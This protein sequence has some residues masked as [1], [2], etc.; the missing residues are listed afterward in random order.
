M[1]VTNCVWCLVATWSIALGG[2]LPAI[3]CRAVGRK[4][5][6]R[7]EQ[8]SK[9]DNSASPEHLLVRLICAFSASSIYEKL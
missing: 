7:L 8:H 5:E 1:V 2:F 3:S 9:H 6:A 4:H